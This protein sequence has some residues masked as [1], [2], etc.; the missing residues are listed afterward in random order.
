MS[1]YKN[2]FEM[3]DVNKNGS[4]AFSEFNSLLQKLYEVAGKDQ[5]TYSIVKDLYDAIDVR[6]DGKIDPHEWNAA[7]VS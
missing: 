7:F 4:I 2:A 6:K 3:F 5:Q 1:G